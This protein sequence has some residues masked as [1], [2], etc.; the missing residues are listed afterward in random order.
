MASTKE[1]ERALAG[2]VRASYV[3]VVMWWSDGWMD[4]GPFFFAL[5]CVD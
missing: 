3:V 5:S 1:Y 4:V 2:R